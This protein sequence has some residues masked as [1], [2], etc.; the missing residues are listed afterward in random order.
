MQHKNFEVKSRV[1]IDKN[2]NITAKQGE[3]VWLEE[4]GNFYGALSGEFIVHDGTKKIIHVKTSNKLYFE[5]NR[6]QVFL[7]EEDT[8]IDIPPYTNTV[9]YQWELWVHL[10]AERRNECFDYGKF[11]IQKAGRSL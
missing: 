5:T 10:P 4:Y 7:T 9:N 2:G 11:I 3:T 6:V 8:N 1:N